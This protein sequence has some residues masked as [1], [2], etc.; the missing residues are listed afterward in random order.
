MTGDA[1]HVMAPSG[2]GVNMALH[3]ALLLG[4]ALVPLLSASD[5]DR[6]ALRSTLRDYERDMM[7]RAKDEMETSEQMLRMCYGPR[8]G[9]EAFTE[10]MQTLMAGGEAGGPPQ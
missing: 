2:E 8:G 4:Q 9:A 3:D 5:L 1:A 6:A 7:L 10:M